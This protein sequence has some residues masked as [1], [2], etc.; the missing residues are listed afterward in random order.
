MRKALVIGINKYSSPNELNGCVN[1]ARAVAVML[2][3]NEDLSH[4]CD[5]KYLL[6]LDATK[7]N[8]ITAITDLYKNDDELAV[9]YFSGHGMDNS[10]DGAIVAVDNEYI[11]FKDIVDI[12]DS[13][14]TR[15]NVIILDCCF[16]GRFGNEQ[17]IGDKT[18]LGDNTVILTA[19]NPY[20]PAIDDGE[21]KHGTFTNLLLGALKGG[22]GDILGRITPGSIYSYVDQA[23]GSWDQRPYFKANVSSFISLR[24]VKEKIDL[25]T[26]KSAMTYFPTKDFQYQL[27]PS[28]ED[29]N[30]VNSTEHTPIEPYAKD[31]NVNIMK[32]LQKL[33]Q[34]GLAFPVGEQY[35]YFAAM[36]SQK[37]ELTELGKHYWRL[38]KER[39]I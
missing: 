28:Y 32:I 29:T 19:C 20:E 34:N 3:N 35:M 17:I 37:V 11:P 33:Y 10:D 23:L 30:V 12:V 8:I 16:S 6:D 2:E 36:H 25:K 1:D 7:S 13:S 18:I 21:S 31:E 38:C 15:Y 4:N 26:L 5:V 14:K 27:D 39:R 24:T 22:A 9:L